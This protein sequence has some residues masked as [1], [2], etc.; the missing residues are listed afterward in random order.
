MRHT[1]RPCVAPRQ[2]KPHTTAIRPDGKFAYVVSQE[3][4]KQ[5]VRRGHLTR[6]ADR[7]DCAKPLRRQ[8]RPGHQRGAYWT[9]T[10]SGADTRRRGRLVYRARITVLFGRHVTPAEARFLA[11]VGG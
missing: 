6:L 5:Y 2:A 9:P 11:E 7:M 3:P 8:T 4:G 1:F 10:R